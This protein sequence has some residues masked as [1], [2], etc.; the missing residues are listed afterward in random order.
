MSAPAPEPGDRMR[1]HTGRRFE[2]VRKH[3]C[4]GCWLWWLDERIHL[5]TFLTDSEFRGLRA[6]PERRVVQ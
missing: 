2:Y 6:T 4:G 3:P 1:T 5:A